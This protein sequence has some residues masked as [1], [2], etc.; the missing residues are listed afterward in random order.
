MN[1]VINNL[2][3]LQSSIFKLK[4]LKKKRPHKLFQQLFLQE[5]EVKIF[6]NKE[7][8]LWG[9]IERSGRASRHCDTATKDAISG[10]IKR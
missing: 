8:L 3:C 2:Q 7:T 10:F 1:F 5:N 9:P 4:L 6:L